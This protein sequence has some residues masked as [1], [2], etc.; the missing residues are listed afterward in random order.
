MDEQD[1][2]QISFQATKYYKGCGPE[3]FTVTGFGWDNLCLIYPPEAGREIIIY[4]CEISRRLD[5]YDE[6]QP[7]VTVLEIHNIA[8][9]T[10]MA[11]ANENTRA[12]AELYSE[13]LTAGDF[14]G[15]EFEDSTFESNFECERFTGDSGAGNYGFHLYN[16]VGFFFIFHLFTLRY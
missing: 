13:T 7:N 8:I 5:R 3:T 1:D 11:S 12:K 10:G 14:C 2:G 9:S 4:A 15:T 16:L 6:T